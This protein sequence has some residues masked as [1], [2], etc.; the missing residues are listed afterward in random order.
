[1][2]IDLRWK[3]I[4][5]LDFSSHTP[6]TAD[7]REL[8]AMT[9]IDEIDASHNTVKSIVN[10]Q[11]F[12]NLSS[13]DISHNHL[14]PRDCGLSSLPLTLARLNLSHNQLTVDSLILRDDDG[15][16]EPILAR[17]SGLLE[18][19]LSH[20]WIDDSGTWGTTKDGQPT[21]PEKPM[22]PSSIRVLSLA[23]NRR[24]E[25]V[26]IWCWC[27]EHLFDVHLEGNTVTQLESLKVLARLSPAIQRLSIAGNPV[28]LNY[29]AKEIVD[30]FPELYSLDGVAVRLI[31]PE[32]HNEP[33]ESNSHTNERHVTSLQE[34]REAPAADDLNTQE[35]GDVTATRG[36]EADGEGV[37]TV[38]A[39]VRLRSPAKD[40]DN[41]KALSLLLKSSLTTESKTV[42]HSAR[43]KELDARIHELE[44]LLSS[45]QQSLCDIDNEN[46][47]LEKQVCDGRRLVSRQCSE[48]KALKAHVSALRD[49][50]GHME[51]LA[52]K[53][54]AEISYAERVQSMQGQRAERILREKQKSQRV[55]ARAQAVAAYFAKQSLNPTD[56]SAARPTRSSEMRNAVTKQKLSRTQSASAVSDRLK[57]R[58]FVE[59]QL[60]NGPA[61]DYADTAVA[62]LFRASPSPPMSSRDR[63][64]QWDR[65]P[66]EEKWRPRKAETHTSGYR[67]ADTLEEEGCDPSIVIPHLM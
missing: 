49:A 44:M 41:T 7:E 59:Y 50:V 9:A 22:L 43:M 33:E 39:R 53:R 21:L 58:S 30:L 8:E 56:T 28:L 51:L 66:R 20:N 34:D 13:L 10:L 46:A 57:S 35:N 6:D 23:E 11:A 62:A 61:D 52:Q 42:H 27:C 18:L 2:R 37:E 31:R 3:H 17:Y 55:A 64:M 29:S 5:T 60:E 45:T 65:S 12:R 32:A 26:A 1:M 54:G 15:N 63:V 14:G 67:A 19:D 4:D 40:A 38:P 48:A 36:K 25:N 24:V 47:L 16:I